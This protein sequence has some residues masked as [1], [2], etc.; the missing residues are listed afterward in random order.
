MG[1]PGS[2]RNLSIQDT[3]PTTIILHPPKL[4]RL[5]TIDDAKMSR[6][7]AMSLQLSLLEA[8]DAMDR[9]HTVVSQPKTQ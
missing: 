7:V 4:L 8:M 1:G 5:F 3:R 9:Q 2:P 6:V